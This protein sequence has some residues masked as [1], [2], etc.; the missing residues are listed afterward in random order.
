M[1]HLLEAGDIAQ[2]AA[3]CAPTPLCIAGALGYDDKPLAA[4]EARDEF[5]YAART[6]AVVD[7]AGAFT[8]AQAGDETAAAGLVAGSRQGFQ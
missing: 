8:I 5:D 1:P 6:Y 4:A 3:L 2:A 7:A